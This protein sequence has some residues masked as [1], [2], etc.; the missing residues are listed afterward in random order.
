MIRPVQREGKHYFLWG[1]Q[2]KLPKGSA[3]W[4]IPERMEWITDRSVEGMRVGEQP[5]MQ[6]QGALGWT[7]REAGNGLLR[8]DE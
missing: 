4:A 1:Q 6:V 3:I 8:N 5:F 7:N 2:G